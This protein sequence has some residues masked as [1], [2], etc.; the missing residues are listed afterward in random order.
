MY[1]S[2]C[3]YAINILSRNICTPK[4]SLY[5]CTYVLCM[6]VVYTCVCTHNT[7]TTCMCTCMSYCIAT[8]PPIIHTY[9][10]HHAYLFFNF[11]S[12]RA[13][14]KPLAILSGSTTCKDAVVKEILKQL[15]T[16]KKSCQK[17]RGGSFLWVVE[18]GLLQ[19][20]AQAAF[21]HSPPFPVYT[22]KVWK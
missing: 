1:I 21:L 22:W 15:L 11:T 2:M 4:H 9:M 12:F 20:S 7:C 3:E 16:Y 8:Y 6:V 18:W 14:G 13:D 17:R 19:P 5:I 10:Y